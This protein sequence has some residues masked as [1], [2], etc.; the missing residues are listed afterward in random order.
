MKT[1]GVTGMSIPDPAA[2]EVLR[3]RLEAAA[4]VGA[5]VWPPFETPPAPGADL[6]GGDHITGVFSP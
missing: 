1:H 2:L 3:Q 6:Q 4:M 5:G